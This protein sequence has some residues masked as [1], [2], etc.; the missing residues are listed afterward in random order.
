M[1]TTLR[2]LTLAI[3]LLLPMSADGQT[4]GG[5][6]GGSRWGSTTTSRPSS[7]SQPS[8]GGLTGYRSPSPSRTIYRSPIVRTTDTPSTHRRVERP[9][10][11]G[12]SHTHYGSDDIDTDTPE[13]NPEDFSP[14]G[15]GIFLGIVGLGMFG[16]VIAILV[17][18]IRDGRRRNSTF[19]GW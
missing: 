18:R 4:T 17:Q 6:F 8:M 5:S 11:E 14:E 3:A 19:R 1:N 15:V 2:N 16:A 12:V 7:S 9:N 10:V 13:I